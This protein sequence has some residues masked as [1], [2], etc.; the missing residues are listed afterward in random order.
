ML[1]GN[2]GWE[3]LVFQSNALFINSLESQ[4]LWHNLVFFSGKINK[5]TICMFISKKNVYTCLKGMDSSHWDVQWKTCLI[6]ERNEFKRHPLVKTNAN[7]VKAV[8]ST[9]FHFYLQCPKQSQ[10]LIG[11]LLVFWLRT[12]KNKAEKCN[13]TTSSP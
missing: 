1:T 7:K 6:Q 12:L 2:T 4:G 5:R 8:T 13:T 3:G 9:W 10:S 11:P